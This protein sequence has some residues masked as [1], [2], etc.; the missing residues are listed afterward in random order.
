MK[1]CLDPSGIDPY[2][3]VYTTSGL[4][5]E[6]DREF[7]MVFIRTYHALSFSVSIPKTYLEGYRVGG[8]R[9]DVKSKVIADSLRLTSNH[10][11]RSYVQYSIVEERRFIGWLSLLSP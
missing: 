4:S 1:D 5:I 3:I 11:R 10:V 6:F 2:I 8:R 7:L 9:A